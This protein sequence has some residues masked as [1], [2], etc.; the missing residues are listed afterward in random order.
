MPLIVQLPRAAKDT[1]RPEDEVAPTV[2]SGSPTSGSGSGPYAIVW[3]AFAIVNDWLT[4]G[5]AL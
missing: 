4:L 1:D 5:A 3:L 2:K